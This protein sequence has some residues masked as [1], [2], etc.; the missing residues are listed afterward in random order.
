MTSA[1]PLYLCHLTEPNQ[2][3]IACSWCH[4]L[5]VGSKLK[6]GVRLSLQSPKPQEK[7]N[8]TKPNQ[9]K[10]NQTKPIIIIIMIIMI[11]IVI[12]IVIVIVI[13]LKLCSCLWKGGARQGERPP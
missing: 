8:Q 7:P 3:V 10:P 2:G 6:A 4:G 5:F 1:K 9:T 11:I 13:M 12:V